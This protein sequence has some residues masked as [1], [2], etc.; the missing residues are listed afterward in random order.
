MVG[1]PKLY[2]SY[3]FLIQNKMYKKSVL[4]LSVLRNI[5]FRLWLV[6]LGGGGGGIRKWG[7]GWKN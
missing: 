4:K 5:T 6:M 3:Y 2:L 7:P 1:I